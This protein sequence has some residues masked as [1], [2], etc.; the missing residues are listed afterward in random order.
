MYNLSMTRATI[1]RGFVLPAK[2]EDFVGEV[3]VSVELQNYDDVRDA[4]RGRLSNDSIRRAT[5]DVLVDTGASMLVLPRD[6]VESLG[7]ETI[8]R[9]AVEYADGRRDEVDVAGMVRVVASG[10]TA[11]APCLVGPSGTEPLL[12]QI[13][14]E[15]MDLLV[16]C[17]RNQLVPRPESPYMPSYK[18]K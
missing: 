2:P 7:L 6:L 5:I 10:R 12:G 14:L 15:M 8:D 11:T 13:V 18:I 1:S 17:G 4:A 3:R 16:D 9:S